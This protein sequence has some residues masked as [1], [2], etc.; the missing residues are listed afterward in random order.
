MSSPTFDTMT[1]AAPSFAAA[2]AWFAPLPPWL[3]SNRGAA[4]VSPHTGM[5]ST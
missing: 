5:R 4:I 2:T 3:I 1:T